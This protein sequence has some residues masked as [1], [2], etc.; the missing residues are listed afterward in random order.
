LYLFRELSVHA[1]WTK[2]TV[3]FDSPMNKDGAVKTVDLGLIYHFR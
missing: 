3:S 2:T 1:G